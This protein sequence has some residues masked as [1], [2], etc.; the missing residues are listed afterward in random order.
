VSLVFIQLFT[1]SSSND[2]KLW[3]LAGL[4][5]LSLAE[6]NADK[7]SF[8]FL[9]GVRNEEFCVEPGHCS[10]YFITTYLTGTFHSLYLPTYSAC[11]RLTDHSR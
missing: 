5:P 8:F 7:I 1:F 4:I 2:M 10:T 3:A 9:G 6:C 11:P